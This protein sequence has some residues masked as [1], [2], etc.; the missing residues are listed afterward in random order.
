MLTGYLLKKSIFHSAACLYDDF[1]L[2]I[3]YDHFLLLSF[4]E[5]NSM[6][7]KMKIE[8]KGRKGKQSL[9]SQL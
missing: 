5:A 7:E 3:P 2:F 4:L 6:W 9:I 8:S 1:A